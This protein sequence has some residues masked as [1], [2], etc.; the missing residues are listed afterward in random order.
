LVVSPGVRTALGLSRGIADAAQ[1]LGRPVAVAVTVPASDRSQLRG[2]WTVIGTSLLRAGSAVGFD[3]Q[4]RAS[5]HVTVD[6]VL[7]TAAV[8]AIENWRRGRAAHPAIDP[9]HDYFLR[10]LACPDLVLQR[11]LSKSQLAARDSTCNLNPR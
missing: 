1:Q 10:V 2:P 4:K 8:S 7:T 3:N 6:T 5:T 9:V 11:E